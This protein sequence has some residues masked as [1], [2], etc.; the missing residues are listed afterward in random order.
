M[1]KQ[2]VSPLVK[3]VKMEAR[4]IIATSE[5]TPA[6]SVSIGRGTT[7]TMYSKSMGSVHFD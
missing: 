3:I 2:L 4:C 1:K 7:E 5:S 6:P